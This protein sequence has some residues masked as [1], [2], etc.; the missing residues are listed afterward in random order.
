MR[1]SSPVQEDFVAPKV[2]FVDDEPAVLEALKCA[3]RKEPYEVLVAGTTA[4]AREILTKER[5]DIVV[6][7]HRMRG[8]SGAAF[9]NRVHR[10]YPDTVRIML[11]GEANLGAAVDVINDGLYR[12]LSKPVS[13]SDL[14]RTLNGA[15]QMKR[16]GEEQSRL[17]TE[18]A[19]QRGR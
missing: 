15:M 19:R 14:V 17:R 18:G 11:T 13:P 16:L 1:R 8:E 3:L 12:F 10:E 4:K 7:D 6:S 5:I 9:L 2:L